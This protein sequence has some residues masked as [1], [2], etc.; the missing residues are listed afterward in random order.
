MKRIISFSIGFLIL[1]ALTIH[2]QDTVKTWK[3]GGA[4]GLNINQVALKNWA[5]GGENSIAVSGLVSLFANY[6][7]DKV[8][9]DN[10]L[11]IGYGLVKQG[12]IPFRKSDD[13]FILTSK[14]GREFVKNWKYSAFAE[15]R[16]QMTNGYDYS[17]TPKQTISKIMAP[18][19]LT[20]SAGGE[21]KPNDNFY[22]LVSPVTGKLTFV[23]DKNLS[24]AGAF[25]VDTGKTVKAELGWLINSQYKRKVM[26]GIDFQSKLNLFGAYNNLKYVDV[27]WDNLLILKVNKY[28]N[29]SINAQLLYDNDIKDTDGK[30]K[31]QLKEVIAVGILY[32]F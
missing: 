28:V 14:W 11:E 7:K 27:L 17:K 24:D 31:V 8:S 6:K 15:L 1:S 23:K 32:S 26:E 2:G 25:G 5:A 13:K 22:A 3:T 19:Y 9:W 18:G 20:L 29:A 16:T 21:Y 12:D 10:S 30:A 4:L